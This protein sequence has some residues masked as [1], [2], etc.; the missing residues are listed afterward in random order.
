MFTLSDGTL[1]TSA[2]DLTTASKCEFAFLRKLDQLRG[3]IDK[4]IA[5][6]DKL[7]S[8]TAALGDEHELRVLQ[9]Y[10]DEFGLGVREFARP[11]PLTRESMSEAAA[12]SAQAFRDGADVVFQA[13]MF[14][15]DATTGTAFVGFAD[16]I[17]RQPDGR[18]RVEDTK[19]ARS[20]KVTAVLQLAAYADVLERNDI[21]V[22][23]TVTL[24]LGDGRPSNHLIEELLPVYRVRRRR[25]LE[26]L[27][28][29][30]TE[31]ADGVPAGWGDER[32][33]ICGACDH[34][35]AE[36]ETRRD[37]LL[38][39]NL[40][41]SQRERLARADI[42]T[43][44]QLAESTGTVEGIGARTLE[45]LRAQ[46][47]LQLKAVKGETPPY[48]VISALPVLALP[49][50]DP[51]DIF[52]DF[53]GDPL[54]TD[55]LGHVW[56]LDY[57]FGLIEVDG[58]FRAFWAHDFAEEGRALHD[59][60]NYVTARRAR[61]P[62]M[63]IY[64]YASY[65]RT[66]LAQ[67]AIRHG[68]GED[69]V[70]N[71]FRR[72]VL[73]DLYATVRGA[74]R[75]G[76]PSY[77]IKKLEPLY[78][79]AD[80]RN[81]EGVT[82]AGDSIVEYAEAVALRRLQ[83]FEGYEQKLDKI[84]EYNEY[85]C[86]STLALRDWLRSLAPD[87]ATSG[88]IDE[89]V[90]RAEPTLSA[91]AAEEAALSEALLQLAGDPLT[92]QDDPS[93]FAA[94]LAAA[95]VRYYSREDKKGWWE[96]F[97]RLLE[98]IDEW[99]DDR[100]VLAIQDVE[101]VEDWHRETSRQNLRRILRLTGTAGPGSKFKASDRPNLVYNSDSNAPRTERD[102][103]RARP[104][105]EA[106][107]TEVEDDAA[108]DV[109]IVREVLRRGEEPYSAL[110]IAL[111][112]AGPIAVIAQRNAILEWARSLLAAYPD[113]PQD[114]AGDILLRR[115]PQTQSG[116]LAPVDALE[117]PGL[118]GAIR[119]IDRSYLAVQGPPGTGKTHTGAHAIADL[120]RDGWK[121]GVTAQSHAVIDNFLSGIVRAG[122]N[123]V[124]LAHVSGD[125][126]TPYESVESGKISAWADDQP[127]GYVIGAT[128][129]AFSNEKQIAR[130]QL[131]LLV[132]DEAGQFSLA[133]TIAVS[134][135][136]RRVLLLGD[137]QQL[138]QVSQGTHPQPVDESALGWIADGARVLP[139]EF[140]YF[141]ALTRR[142]DAALTR[143]V[144][145][146][147]YANALHAHECTRDR[148]LDG[149]AS[150]L[151]PVSV[152]HTGNSV[153]SMEEASVVVDLV[154]RLV[155]ARWTDPSSGRT[156]DPLR[157]D[158]IIIVTPYNAQRQL[159][160]DALAAAGFTD[161]Q[162][163]TVDKFQGREAVV[164]IV[165]LA[166]SD[167]SE[168]PRGM[169]F[170]INRNRLNVAI[171][172]AQWASWLVHSPSLTAHLPTTVAAV[173]ELSAFVRL[174]E[175]ADDTSP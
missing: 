23:D 73:V 131:D 21:L 63:H 14:E 117:S 108:D 171:S 106:T 25:L 29:R 164:S 80:L 5:K 76:S 132:I 30:D 121:I 98:P 102:D 47:G 169:D 81:D 144:S 124:Q 75:V 153:A 110:P 26:L 52:F 134:L 125:R 172:R 94:A 130:Q 4:L 149:W 151:H 64:H 55:D 127:G 57:L 88:N 92:V 140:G 104:A 85:D 90:E 6:E 9:A 1:V 7:L 39:A 19:L 150:G 27:R 48:E 109:V 123:P 168:V 113:V 41:R 43:I 24:L 87:A 60:L 161:M 15:E 97:A 152:G 141:L 96:H 146:L 35:E 77:S 86:R 61:H 95:A 91:V 65:E 133:N 3:R 119:D 79:G 118:A 101:V 45:N 159:V 17:T 167:A 89:A 103:P 154:R 83:D 32:F 145:Q 112:P 166:A 174:I 173:K 53:E 46:A 84:A 147:S 155:G 100:D 156:N 50:P 22:D 69:I 11:D 115:P 136:A 107:I 78:M 129:W 72:H 70:D 31:G 163:G 170:L 82:N 143:H 2:S 20:E 59:F 38:V 114:A 36:I 142:M 158:D 128:A 138:P 160:L 34:C 120:V 162:V 33:S 12:L 44:D 42:R 74:L 28:I 18:Y 175:A 49:A 71:L 8:R 165:S 139:G 66:H 135:S 111:V 68:Y 40:R 99:A 148:H 16:F 51:G 58:T 126:T 116:H 122:V 137:P 37:V 62:N 157:P 10:R 56:G 67:L 13:T 105:H 54:Y 93:R